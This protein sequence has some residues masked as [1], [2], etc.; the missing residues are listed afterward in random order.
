MVRLC[1]SLRRSRLRMSSRC[2]TQVIMP[3][4]EGLL[5]LRDDQNVADL[6][7][8]LTNWHALA[9][10]RLH[11]DVTIDIFRA[12][13][14]HM[15]KAFRKFA[16]KTCPRYATRELPKEAQARV[17]QE[18]KTTRKASIGGGAQ[19]LKSF[20]VLNTFK[21]HS[22]GDYAAYIFR[23][24]PTDNYTTQVVRAQYTARHPRLALMFVA[25]TGRARAPSYQTLLCPHKQNPVCVATRTKAPERIP[26]SQVPKA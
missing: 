13:T 26:P 22:L 19:K 21:Y 17:R 25:L 1:V 15:Y 20:N 8:K 6:L 12:A 5:P 10:L 24:G 2:L 9:K 16:Y 7:F 11:T 3:V 4:F 18:Q 23:S 14:H